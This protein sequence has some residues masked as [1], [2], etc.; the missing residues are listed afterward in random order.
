MW[1]GMCVHCVRVWLA[2]NIADNNWKVR[3]KWVNLNQHTR[4]HEYIPKFN[5][6][7][8]VL[9]WCVAFSPAAY[10]GRHIDWWCLAASELPKWNICSLML[11]DILDVFARG[12]CRLPSIRIHPKVV[13]SCGYWW[14]SARSW[15][16]WQPLWTPPTAE[17]ILNGCR[18]RSEGATIHDDG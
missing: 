15:A 2:Q 10:E 18:K 13:V 14:H 12:K 3:Y 1:N 8:C 5:G 17:R 16:T 11:D 9:I 6:G 7:L 4:V